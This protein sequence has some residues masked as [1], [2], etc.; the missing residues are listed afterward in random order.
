MKACPADGDGGGSVPFEA[1][2][3]PKPRLQAS[4]VSFDSIVGER[5]GVVQCSREELGNHA[6][7][8]VGP[9]GGDLGRLGGDRRREESR[10]GLESRFLDTNTSMTCPYS[11]T[12][13]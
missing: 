8:G 7:Q 2:H 6:D 4:V 13:R 12:A 1:P 11:S 3:W 5:G 10:G 9:V